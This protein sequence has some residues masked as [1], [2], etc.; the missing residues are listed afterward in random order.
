M[1]VSEFLQYETNNQHKELLLF[2][3]ALLFGALSY[4]FVALDVHSYQM[5]L[6]RL[7]F[8]FY[9]QELMMSGM[10]RFSSLFPILSDLF[11]SRA[12]IC[13]P[14]MPNSYNSWNEGVRVTRHSYNSN[15]EI[16]SCKTSS[17][18]VRRLLQHML[19][20]KDFPCIVRV[21]ALAM[22]QGDGSDIF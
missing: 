14:P 16:R 13:P 22:S 10:Q 15:T 18:H 17:V 12:D 19:A 4:E 9:H 1:L 20:W 6:L 11:G 3:P 7:L 2:W 5:I 21:K 8:C